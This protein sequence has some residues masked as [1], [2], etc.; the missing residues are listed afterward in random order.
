[1]MERIRGIAQRL[2]A[3]LRALAALLARPFQAIATRLRSGGLL[4]RVGNALRRAGA[5]IGGILL[6]PFRA[7]AAKWRRRRPASG[8]PGRIW[9]A[10]RNAG[11]AIRRLVQRPIRRVQTWWR[12]RGARRAA[13]G[14]LPWHLRLR[15]AIGRALRA[16]FAALERRRRAVGR[17]QILTIRKTGLKRPY[18]YD[19]RATIQLVAD[20]TN[21]I[22]ILGG[23]AYFPQLRQQTPLAW[24]VPMVVG[25]LAFTVIYRRWYWSFR[26]GRQPLPAVLTG[27]M[28]IMAFFTFLTGLTAAILTFREGNGNVLPATVLAYPAIGAWIYAEYTN[29]YARLIRRPY[30]W[31]VR[32]TMFKSA[33]QVM[34]AIVA[35][36]YLIIVTFLPRFDTAGFLFTVAA[37]LAS[38]GLII[39]A[40]ATLFEYIQLRRQR[41]LSPA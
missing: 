23:L 9:Q 13:R 18:S 35:F 8:P 29:F 10:I 34:S 16:P 2:V 36:V 25:L 31:P 6:R 17:P 15:R 4:S 24:A 26:R 38:A 5:A 21:S 1:M 41:R 37:I 39:Q 3:A 19:W 33:F 7:I 12:Q 40:G 30:T 14:D 27:A 11:A 22:V 20:V 28:A 32:V